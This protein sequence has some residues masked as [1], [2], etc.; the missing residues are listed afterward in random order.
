MAGRLLTTGA[1]ET[2]ED[3]IERVPWYSCREGLE[4]GQRLLQSGCRIAA[5]QLE[6]AE[7]LRRCPPPE[8]TWSVLLAP[9]EW[10]SLVPSLASL[11]H[12]QSRPRLHESSNGWPSGAVLSDAVAEI[13]PALPSCGGVFN[14]SV[15]S[16]A[17]TA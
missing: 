16:R 5:R 1:V 12:P 9:E 11:R 10:P 13:T 3:A 4:V 2:I 14:I 15:T 17:C 7:R 8:A 6:T